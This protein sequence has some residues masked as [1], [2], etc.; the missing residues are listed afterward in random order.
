MFQVPFRRITIVALGRGKVTLGIRI[1]TEKLTVI[2][3]KKN[4]WGCY[5]QVGLE[6]V[7]I[8]YSTP[9]AHAQTEP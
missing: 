8:V 4:L 1:E 7:Y 2:Q 3:A 6:L 5:I 9:T